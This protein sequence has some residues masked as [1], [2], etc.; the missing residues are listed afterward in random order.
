MAP[1]GLISSPNTGL[2]PD[3][4]GK[5]LRGDQSAN[6]P[7]GP[8]SQPWAV[9]CWVTSLSFLQSGCIP[10]RKCLNS[11]WLGFPRPPRSSHRASVYGLE[12]GAATQVWK[13]FGRYPPSTEVLAW[14]VGMM[15]Q[16]PGN[17]REL[18][19]RPRLHLHKCW[20]DAVSCENLLPTLKGLTHLQGK[21][22]TVCCFQELK[23]MS[24]HHPKR[25]LVS[26]GIQ[27]SMCGTPTV[28]QTGAC[29]FH[30]LL[31]HLIP[32]QTVRCA[33]SSPFTRR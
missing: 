4:S 22:N 30:P 14:L 16:K 32:T 25:P 2:C 9:G 6:R 17:W 18:P 23:Q 27:V 21:L 13:A 12:R 10:E 28:C 26:R 15:R 29:S 3:S 1:G 33:L 19:A 20:V 8:S 24:R 7:H 5:A 31:Y 11:Q